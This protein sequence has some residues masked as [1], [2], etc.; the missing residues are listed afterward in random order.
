MVALG[1]PCVMWGLSLW[2]T[3]SLVVVCQLSTCGMWAVLLHASRLL[4][5]VFKG[6]KLRSEHEGQGSCP[7]AA[8]VLVE[9]MDTKQVK[10]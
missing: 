3:S 5:T 9:E 4:G 2:C 8:Y 6:W 7:H 1:L 10:E